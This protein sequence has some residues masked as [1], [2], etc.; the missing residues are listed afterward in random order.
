MRKTRV[1]LSKN[2]EVFWAHNSAPN[3]KMLKKQIS[4]QIWAILLSG[5]CFILP[6]LAPY[7][8]WEQ[9]EQK[10]CNSAHTNDQ[11]YIYLGWHLLSPKSFFQ[12]FK[13]TNYELS[14]C[15]SSKLNRFEPSYARMV[16]SW[17]VQ[18]LQTV[19]RTSETCFL[20]YFQIMQKKKIIE[21]ET[22]LLK[23]TSI[24]QM[25]H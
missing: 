20:E 1:D 23:V 10:I 6:K 16:A 21:I 25:S 12:V 17:R 7:Q 19:K 8:F 11:L 24:L 4:L 15:F 18:R 3:M 2:R 13:I 22:F 9:S 14:G 5:K